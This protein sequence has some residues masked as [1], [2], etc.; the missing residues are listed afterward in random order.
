MSILFPLSISSARGIVLKRILGIVLLLLFVWQPVLAD[1]PVSTGAAEPNSGVAQS[2]GDSSELPEPSTDAEP[3]WVQEDLFS[4]QSGTVLDKQQEI[5]SRR[6]EAL[7]RGIDS[8]FGGEESFEEATGTYFQLSAGLRGEAGDGVEP[9]AKVRLRLDLPNTKKRLQLVIESDE[10]EEGVG[11]EV[12]ATPGEDEGALRAGLRLTVRERRRWNF[13][14]TGG[15]KW[16]LPPDPFVEFR[17]RRNQR[18]GRWW[19]ARFEERVTW[20]LQDKWRNRTRLY[21]DRPLSDKLLF[22]ALSQQ[23]WEQEEDGVRLGQSLTFFFRPSERDSY[24]FRSS[25]NWDTHPGFHMTSYGQSVAYRRRLHKQWLF[26]EIEPGIN[27]PDDRDFRTT[28]WIRFKL[29]VVF[30]WKTLDETSRSRPLKE[31][32][33]DIKEE[34]RESEP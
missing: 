10:E 24:A 3:S 1:E 19:L 12:A 31:L 15:V 23:S 7:A 13:S 29:E 9:E 17:F 11:E 2:E 4:G 5:Y 34:V 33:R 26:M 8:L 28:P 22:R 16:D 20:Y 27:W 30:G 21:F 6:V 32:A 18:L 14:V 25:I